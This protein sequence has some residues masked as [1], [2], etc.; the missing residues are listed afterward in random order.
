LDANTG[1]GRIGPFLSKKHIDVM[2]MEM[3]EKTKELKRRTQFGNGF[4]RF[5]K[6][7]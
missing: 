3:L 2:A 4:E 1:I 7:I 6:N 5:L